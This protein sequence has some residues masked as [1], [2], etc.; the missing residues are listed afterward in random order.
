[1]G[2]DTVWRDNMYFV[3]VEPREPGNIG[4]SARA[5]KNMG[6]KNLILVRPQ[7]FPSEEASRFAHNATDILERAT[8]YESLSTA[9]RDIS[10]VVGTT[11]REGKARRIIEPIKD[12]AVSIRAIGSSNRVAFVFGREDRGLTN[13]EINSCGRLMRIPTAEVHPSLNLSHAVLVVAYELS[14]LQDVG[15]EES[16]ITR[17]RMGE[18]E[19]LISHAIET[20]GYGVRGS[21]DLSTSIMRNVKNVLARAGLTDWEANMIVGLCKRIEASLNEGRKCCSEKIKLYSK[22]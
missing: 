18:L 9:V 17:E 14:R 2:S 16:F 22:K 15:C 19:A 3:L 20:L 21:R 1:M 6:F 8:V 7:N 11:R 5:M 10:F 12:L 13:S 4:A